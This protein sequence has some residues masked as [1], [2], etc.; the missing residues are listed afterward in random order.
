VTARGLSPNGVLRAWLDAG[1][2][3]IQLRAKNL[4]LGPFVDLAAPMAATCRQAGAIF[5]VND[6]ADVARLAGA[7]GVHL[8]QDDLSPAEARQLLPDA[9]WIGVSTHNEVQINAALETPA[10]Y[11]ATGPVFAT[12]TKVNPDP[13]IGVAGVARA[14]ALVR[15]T[16]RTLVAIGGITLDTAPSVIEAGAGSIAVISDLLAGDDLTARARAFLSAL[17]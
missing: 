8:G 3:L 2:R 16:G 15:G 7:A 10:T 13:V 14:A 12:R 9:P 5:I 11:L 1:V 17:E 4:S 6:R